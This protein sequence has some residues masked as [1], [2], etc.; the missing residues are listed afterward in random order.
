MF[1]SVF[2]RAAV[3]TMPFPIAARKFISAVSITS[4][5]YHKRAHAAGSI[6]CSDVYVLTILPPVS[7]TPHAVACLDAIVLWDWALGL[8]REWRFVRRRAVAQRRWTE[9]Q[10]H[11]QIWKTQWTPVKVAYLFCR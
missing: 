2:A 6:L 7:L 9:L 5:P 1:L 10:A 8:P 3:F 4:T 11:I